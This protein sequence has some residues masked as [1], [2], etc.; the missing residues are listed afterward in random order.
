ML[1]EIRS[2]PFRDLDQVVRIEHRCQSLCCFEPFPTIPTHSSTHN[3]LVNKFMNKKNIKKRNEESAVS[4]GAEGWK[5]V[6]QL[7]KEQDEKMERLPKAFRI[8]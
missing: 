8:I 3:A 6:L 1:C 7:L 4:L 2:Q 5:D